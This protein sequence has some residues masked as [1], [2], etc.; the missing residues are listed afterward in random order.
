MAASRARGTAAG[1]AVRLARGA[2]GILGSGE[3]LLQLSGVGEGVRPLS[4]EPLG[5]G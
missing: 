1:E 4:L 3:P 2:P 5:A